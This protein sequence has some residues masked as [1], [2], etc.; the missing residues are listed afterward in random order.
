MRLMLWDKFLCPD[1]K[2]QDLAKSATKT[3]FSVT[4]T[5]TDVLATVPVT[6]KKKL[7]KGRKG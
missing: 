4:A 3:G 7:P 6:M 1:V 5:S 2:G